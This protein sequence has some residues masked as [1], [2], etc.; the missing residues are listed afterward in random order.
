MAG[1]LRE[2]AGHITSANSALTGDQ[3]RFMMQ[4]EKFNNSALIQTSQPRQLDNNFTQGLSSNNQNQAPQQVALSKVYAS[5][6]KGKTPTATQQA[7]P[8]GQQVITGHALQDHLQHF[9]NS[10]ITS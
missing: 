8:S 10:N 4:R 2:S 7:Q 5:Q 3:L 9:T 1:S 6:P